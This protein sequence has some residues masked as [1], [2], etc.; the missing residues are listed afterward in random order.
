M[1]S[2]QIDSELGMNV[3]ESASINDDHLPSLEDQ[4]EE[5]SQNVEYE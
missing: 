2:S 5:N 1:E 3:D 4:L